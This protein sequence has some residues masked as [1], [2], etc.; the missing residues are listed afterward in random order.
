MR[1]LI[2]I[3]LTSGGCDRLFSTQSPEVDSL[4][5]DAADATTDAYDHCWSPQDHEHD[6]DGDG[7]PNGCDNCPSIR[8]PDQLD[9]DDDGVGDVCDPRMGP[10]KIERFYSFEDASVR[11]AFFEEGSGDWEIA[12]GSYTQK[13]VVPNATATLTMNFVNAAVVV[14]V[15][16]MTLPVNGGPFANIAVVTSS[17]GTG[18][19]LAC[20]Y[21]RNN[22]PNDS[23]LLER[24]TSV[25]SMQVLGSLTFPFPIQLATVGTGGT[26]ACKLGSNDPHMHSLAEVGPEVGKIVLAT[27]RSALE[28]GSL[29]VITAQPE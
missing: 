26:P 21:L 17:T 24:N 27:E 4:L 5:G 28:I 25:S 11:A 1:W 14:T 19:G 15:A 18:T 13:L 7:D 16:N 20:S 8:N 9:S 2:A 29:M 6:E 23:S 10:D 22:P 12:N 3:A